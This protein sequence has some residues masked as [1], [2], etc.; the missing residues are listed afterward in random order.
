MESDFPSWGNAM[1]RIGRVLNRVLA[2]CMFLYGCWSGNL[3]GCSE[4]AVEPETLT[5]GMSTA[6]SGPAASLGAH[7][8]YGVLAAFHE[9]NR[10]RA[11]GRKR[12]ELVVLDDRYEPSLTV[13]NMHALID[14]HK[15]L[16]IIGNVGTPTAITAAPIAQR[17]HTP[18]FGAFTGANVLRKP[19]PDRFV[20]NY[21]AS[22]AE[23][24]A[25]IVDALVASGI[26]AEEIGFFTQN[27]SYGDDGFFGGLAA[28]R[29]HYKIQQSAVAH[30]RYT[31]NTTS[32]ES[33]LAELLLHEPIPKAVIMVGT[34]A[35]C[36]KFI[37]L[38]KENGYTP[39]FLGVSFIGS[40]A[41]VHVLGEYAQGV[42][43]TQVVPHFDSEL[44]IALEYRSAMTQMDEDIPY[45]FV[46]MEGYLAARILIKALA[47]IQGDTTREKVNQALEELGEFDLGTG[48]ELS[49]SLDDHQ[50]SS[51]VW[52]VKLHGQSAKSINWRELIRPIDSF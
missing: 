4:P 33:A 46:S 16:G 14:K 40:E 27:D 12:L 21:R 38:A 29:K 6:L 42:I 23:E 9:A 31:R 41:L 10:S 50:A 15:V 36:A 1:N 8:R 24:T 28:L 47:Q 5:F 13:P 48:T 32:V 34:Y 25:A 30:G 45:S 39:L 3:G 11:L 20:I 22:Y 37:R 52:P 35:P 19:V 43:I 2:G 51:A 49:L 7:M 17:T 26:T 18:F 44:R